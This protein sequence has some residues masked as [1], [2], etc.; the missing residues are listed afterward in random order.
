MTSMN[1]KYMGSN[2]WHG[3][4]PGQAAVTSNTGILVGKCCGSVFGGE[5]YLLPW[6]E[7]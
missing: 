1:S 5:L 2:M 4:K 6:H 3:V 7:W